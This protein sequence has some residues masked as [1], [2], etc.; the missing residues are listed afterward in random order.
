MKGPHPPLSAASS[1]NGLNSREQMALILRIICSDTIASAGKKPR[2]MGSLLTLRKAG[3]YTDGLDLPR[4]MA[5]GAITSR[6]PAGKYG[7]TS[8]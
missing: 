7:K 5:R 8:T 6:W 2:G 1:P 3:N 4:A